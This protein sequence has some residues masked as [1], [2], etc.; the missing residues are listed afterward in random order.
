MS[1]GDIIGV[2]IVYIYV[3]SLLLIF[4]FASK[5]HHFT[6]RKLIHILVGNIVFVVPLFESRWIM[7][8]LAAAPFI[9]ITYFISP[10]SPLSASSKTSASGHGLGLLYYSISWTLLALLFFDYPVVIAVG[11]ICMSYGDGSASLVGKKYGKH[12]LKIASDDKSVEGSTAMFLVSISVIIIT[13]YIFGSLPVNLLFIPLVV[14]IA[15]IVEI[16]SVRGLDNILVAISS[17]VSYYIL[18]HL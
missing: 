18:I 15:T 2:L 17:S 13:L 10:I 5:K 1:T 7:G 16:F 9:L 8:F 11:I 14:G 4:D 12:L 3:G 6:N